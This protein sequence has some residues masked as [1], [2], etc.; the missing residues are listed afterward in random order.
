MT[1]TEELI[2]T[3]RHCKKDVVLHSKGKPH[4]KV[5]VGHDKLG[6]PERLL[7]WLCPKCNGENR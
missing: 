4:V 3:C 1:K 2:L 5:K 7:S 6:W